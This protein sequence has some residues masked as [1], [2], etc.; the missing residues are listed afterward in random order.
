MSG[1]DDDEVEVVQKQHVSDDLYWQAQVQ[2]THSSCCARAD[3]PV[4]THVL[5]SPD[6]EEQEGNDDLWNATLIKTT[7]FAASSG[8]AC[9]YRRFSLE[10]SHQAR[11]LGSGFPS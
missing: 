8:I 1:D 2:R 10:D 7:A 3:N 9:H 5:H 11:Y 4:A 6:P